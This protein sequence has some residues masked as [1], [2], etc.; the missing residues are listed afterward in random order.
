MQTKLN[1]KIWGEANHLKPFQ[2]FETYTKQSSSEA[3]TVVF[4]IIQS[5]I[6]IFIDYISLNTFCSV[7]HAYVNHSLLLNSECLPAVPFRQQTIE[8]QSRRYHRD[9]VELQFANPAIFQKH[10]WS[11]LKIQRPRSPPQTN[12]IGI[13]GG[14]EVPIL[15]TN[16]TGGSTGLPGLRTI[17][18]ECRFALPDTTV[19]W[20]SCGYRALEM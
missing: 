19:T 12:Q 6:L 18:T 7:Q 14:K 9:Q 17:E 1:V 10:F 3:Q 16:S 13:R 20:Q 4:Q 2:I 11:F 5:C 15:L 8:C